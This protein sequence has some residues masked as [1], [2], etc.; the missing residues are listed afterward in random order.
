MRCSV[1]FDG[2]VGRLEITFR[3]QA[4]INSHSDLTGRVEKILDSRIRI[5][6]GGGSVRL[7]DVDGYWPARF[8]DFTTSSS[9]QG[10]QQDCV[11]GSE[12]FL[13][14]RAKRPDGAG[15]V[16]RDLEVSGGAVVSVWHVNRLPEQS[17]RSQASLRHAVARL[18]SELAVA[19]AAC[20]A[21]LM[22]GLVGNPETIQYLRRCSYLWPTI[23]GDIDRA[24]LNA[25]QSA[26][27]RQIWDSVC[28]ETWCG[29]CWFQLGTCQGCRSR[30]N[31]QDRG[32]V[33]DTYNT[34]GGHVVVSKG[35][36]AVVAQSG[37]AGEIS[38]D[39][40]VGMGQIDLDAALAS[41]RASISALDE[42]PEIREESL[43]D[44]DGVSAGQPD[45]VR[46]KLGVIGERLSGAGPAAAAALK[47]I[48]TLISS[49]QG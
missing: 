43:R 33:G 34:G 9:E 8:A 1:A 16:Q 32:F 25:L 20:D 3:S 26:S 13:I 48:N 6:R 4:P 15:L 5:G 42:S 21:R 7:R 10:L 19:E 22:E 27:Q 46:A 45:G 49:L 12:P 28:S 29:L 30:S 31:K 37:G 38:Q 39:S 24:C 17:R 47:L 18:G 41:L 44:L 40:D 23:E 11:I 36:S 35:D 2:Y 14:A